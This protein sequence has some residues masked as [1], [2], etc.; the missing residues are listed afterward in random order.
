VDLHTA[1]DRATECFANTLRQVRDDQWVLPTPDP[2]WSVRDLVNHVVGGNWRYVVLLSGAPTVDVEALRSLDHL[3]DDP[4]QDFIDTSAEVADAFR[5]TGA[6]DQ[7]VHH[8]LGDRSGADLLVMRVIEH[9]VHGWDLARAI[10]ADDRI[11]PAVTATLLSCFDADSNLLA[12][13][14]FAPSDP[15]ANAEPQRRLLIVTGRAE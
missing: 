10:G 8:R 13:S 7:T 3:G 12:S 9:A 2:G 15:P 4:L 1:L 5:A 14:S 6:L 11:D